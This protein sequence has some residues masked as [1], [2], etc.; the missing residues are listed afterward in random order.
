M[1]SRVVLTH[2]RTLR[3][4]VSSPT[5]AVL[6]ARML[7]WSAL[8][9]VLK[10]TIPLHRLVRLMRLE[11]TGKARNREREAKVVALSGWVFRSRPR[12]GR[13]NCLDRSLVAYRFL[14]RMN[15]QPELVVGFGKDGEALLGHVWITVDKQPVHDPADSLEPYATIVVFGSDGLALK[16]ERATRGGG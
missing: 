3:G 14:S 4:L 13:D 1:R 6:L 8:L 11:P 15:T 16:T 9:P 12:R 10:R 7:G 2:V 5:D